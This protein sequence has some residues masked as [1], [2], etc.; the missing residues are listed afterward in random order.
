MGQR[1]T[2]WEYS[3]KLIAE[4]PLLGHGTGSFAKE[5]ERSA[6]NEHLITKNPHNEFLMISVQLGLLGLLIYLG[7]L[8]NQYYCA[9]KLPNEEK[10]L[11]QGLFTAFNCYQFIQQPSFGSYRRALVC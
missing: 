11:A 2:F 4:K 9:K 8:A 10:W 7:F 1:Y 6:H 3:I 5:Y